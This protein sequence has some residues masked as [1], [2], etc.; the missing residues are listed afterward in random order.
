MGASKD[1]TEIF[2]NYPIE[3]NLNTIKWKFSQDKFKS[4]SANMKQLYM[5]SQN[6][7]VSTD[8]DNEGEMIFR[9]WQQ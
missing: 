8:F 3:L 1:T 5:N 7:I 9:N 4:L 6:I 2:D